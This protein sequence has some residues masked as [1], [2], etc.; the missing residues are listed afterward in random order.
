MREQA[1]RIDSL[2]SVQHRFVDA[3]KSSSCLNIPIPNWI[4]SLVPCGSHPEHV[5]MLWS[6]QPMFFGPERNQKDM[7]EL[8]KWNYQNLPW[9]HQENLILMGPDFICWGC[10][11]WIDNHGR[12][13]PVIFQAP[14]DKIPAIYSRVPSTS[15]R[16]DFPAMLDDDLARLGQLIHWFWKIVTLWT[17]QL[18]LSQSRTSHPCNFKLLGVVSTTLKNI[19]HLGW[20]FPIY[21]KIKNVPNHQSVYIA[22]LWPSTPKPGWFPKWRSTFCLQTSC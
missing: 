4:N 2:S 15:C 6:R 16:G 14:M 20:L 21:G 18:S 10:C 19:S 17:K 11:F 9:K 22:A 12:Y 5:G 3:W 8:L 7:V 13:P 1:K